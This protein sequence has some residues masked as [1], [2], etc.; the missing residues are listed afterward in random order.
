MVRWTA[1]RNFEAVLDL[2]AAGALDPSVLLTHEHALA[3]AAEAYNAL[4]GDPTALAIVLRYPGEEQA[5]TDRLLARVTPPTRP[6][7]PGRARVGVIGPAGSATRSAC[8]PGDRR[9]GWRVRRLD[10]PRGLVTM[11]PGATR[12]PE[13]AVSS[14]QVRERHVAC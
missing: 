13:T 9:G 3:D 8:R 1:G 7:A 10:R 2:M 11:P 6:A 4:V 5:P 14:R 12:P